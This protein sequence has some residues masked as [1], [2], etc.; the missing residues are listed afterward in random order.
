MSPRPRGLPSF[1]S[2]VFVAFVLVISIT[3]FA[4]LAMNVVVELQLASV[5]RVDVAVT[6]EP[7][8]GENYLLIGSDTREFVTTAQDEEAF[9]DTSDAGGT[10]SD[11]IMVLHVYPGGTRSVLVSFPRDLWVDIPGVGEGKINSAFNE[12]PQ[13]VID[14]I[15]QNYDVP[16]HRYVEVN[17]D[18]FRGLVDAIGTVPVFFP[19]PAR[20]ELTGLN[21]PLFGCAELGG[22]EALAFVR[23]R[24]LEVLDP[25]TKRWRN[26][27][28]VP[29]IGRIARQQA[30]L[31]ELGSRAMDSALSNPFK[32]PNIIDSAIA[33]L[34]ID[35]EFGRGDL[36]S[37]VAAFRGDSGAGLETITLPW[38][39]GTEDGQQ[40]LFPKE[41]EADAVLAMLRDFTEPEPLPEPVDIPS[42]GE[43][44][45]RVL[46][47]G[48]AEGA[49]GRALDKLA[50]AGFDGAGSG[51]TDRRVN[52]SQIRYGEGNEGAAQLV[53]GYVGGDH[54][55]VEDD[56][57]E[58]A[59]VV[60]V[61]GGEFE[62]ISVPTA[63]PAPTTATPAAE[64]TAAAPVANPLAPVPGCPG[65]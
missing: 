21:V 34:K 6:E 42:Q 23:S 10:R 9:G 35:D 47:G 26:A 56:S 24:N 19:A 44:S 20:D 8:A 25:E 27:D 4:F 57:I 40:V 16:I 37:L 49:A 39:D 2:R 36:F 62:G 11:T 54:E 32:A 28:P 14:T 12:G 5:S 7:S 52:A 61:I 50:Q 13:K 63:A 1:G 33:K 59:D 29:D 31:R 45:V 41:P 15:Q 30:F 17:F 46:N 53:A 3:L 60:L 18:T 22:E 58:G 38:T 48:G 65:G 51:N 43:V 64:P 55:L